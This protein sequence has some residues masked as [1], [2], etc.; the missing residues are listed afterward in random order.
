MERVARVK[1]AA[2]GVQDRPA[3]LLGVCLGDTY[4][5]TE[6]NLT[7]RTGFKLPFLVG[8]SFL[9]DRFAV[10]SSRTDTIEPACRVTKASSAAG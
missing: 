2:G 4:R 7:D 1:K 10:D 6:V 3:V 9:A 8:R 5:V